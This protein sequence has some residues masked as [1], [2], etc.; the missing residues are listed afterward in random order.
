MI[1][2]TSAEPFGTTRSI[3]K[4]ALDPIHGAKGFFW[5]LVGVHS[6]SSQ[7]PYDLLYLLVDDD[8]SGSIG[9]YSTMRLNVG[10][11]SRQDVYGARFCYPAEITSIRLFLTREHDFI[12][13][14]KR[15]LPGDG[16][17]TLRGRAHICA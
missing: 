14:A 5:T 15:G 16:R 13:S 4:Q 1:L 7:R 11:Q 9:P 8:L 12:R 3:Y 10:E 6:R 17:A 2:L